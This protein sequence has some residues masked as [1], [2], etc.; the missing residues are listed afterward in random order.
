VKPWHPYLAALLLALPGS[1]RAEPL[2]EPPSTVQADSSAAQQPALVDTLRFVPLPTDSLLAI[3]EEIP[4]TP[5]GGTSLDGEEW[6]RTP[7]GDHL[8]T[9]ADEWRAHGDDIERRDL[10]LD[11]NRVDRVRIGVAGQIQSPETMYPRLGG[12]LEYSTGR[13]RTLYGAQIEQPLM[14]PG[15]LALGVSMVRCTDHSDLQQVDDLENTLALL[16]GRQDYRDYFEREGVGAYLAWRVPDF[17]TVSLHYRDDRYRSLGLDGGTRSWF[18][19]ERGLR[20]NPP[21]DEG[22]AH[23]AVL[24]LERLAHQTRRSRAGFY[25]WVEAERAGRGLGGDF[26]YGR[27][28]ADLRQVLRLSPATTLALRLVGGSAFQGTLPVQKQFTVG[29]VDGLRAHSFARF[30]GDQ[31]LLGQAEYSVE[32]WRLHAHDFESGLNVL[33]FVDAGRAWSNP[34]HVW[35]PGRQRLGVDGGFGFATADDNLRIYFAKDLQKPDSD[36]VISLRLQR[37]F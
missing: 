23:A 2:P 6:L 9:D 31:M 10:T 5:P 28:L 37:P 19:R 24:R 3:P 1:A 15:R 33:A 14:P 17:S 30:R 25:H 12:R 32:L 34:D 4:G 13:K 27:A 36:F 26:E 29:G 16:L 21:I 7:F 20:D 8:L 11:Y 18:E 35:D 22:E